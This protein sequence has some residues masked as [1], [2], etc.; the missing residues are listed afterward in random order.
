MAPP[1]RQGQGR[2]QSSQLKT[3]N[4]FSSKTLQADCVSCALRGKTSPALV[5]G[6]TRIRWQQTPA[7]LGQ[8]AE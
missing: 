5:S 7:T 6:L 4:A 2:L 8:D 1:R 3:E